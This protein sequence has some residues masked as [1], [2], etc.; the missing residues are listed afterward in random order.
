[1]CI[2]KSAF[3]ASA[4]VFSVAATNAYGNED[5]ISGYH[6]NTAAVRNYSPAPR[7]AI[8]GEARGSFAQARAMHQPAVA[9]TNPLL[10][11]FHGLMVR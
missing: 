3:I 4:L 8:S 1:M 9:K 2:L 5:L 10:D 6:G 7:L 11:M